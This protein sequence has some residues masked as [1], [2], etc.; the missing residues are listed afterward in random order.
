MHSNLVIKIGGHLISRSDGFSLDLMKAYAEIILRRFTGGRWCVVV[1]GGEEARRYVSAARSLGFSE[2]FC[3]MLAIKVTRIHA[4][5]FS[6]LIG[7]KA[8][9]AIPE[10]LEQL[11]EYSRDGVIVVAGGLQPAQST[12]AVAALAAEALGAEKLII[13]TDV[14]GVYTDD[15]KKNPGAKLLKEVTLSRLEEILRESSHAAGEYKLIDQLAL[16]VLR[17]SGITAMVIDGRKVENLEK[18]LAGEKV[19]TLIIPG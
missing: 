7:E 5:M 4:M 16:K 9:R 6:A 19:G 18:A 1:G 2:S 17:R 11:L 13:A 15:P 8:C 3:D 12:T 14:E 10:S